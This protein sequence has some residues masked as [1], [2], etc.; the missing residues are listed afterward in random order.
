VLA[1]LLCAAGAREYSA[2]CAAVDV[3]VL[4]GS[5]VGGWLTRLASPTDSGRTEICTVIELDVI[6]GIGR[7]NRRGAVLADMSVAC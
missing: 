3:G 2:D 7:D 1:G 4:K 5:A 6:T